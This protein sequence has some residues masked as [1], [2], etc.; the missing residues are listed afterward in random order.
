MIHVVQYATLHFSSVVT[1]G[2]GSHSDFYNKFPSLLLINQSCNCS[3]GKLFFSH[4]M[5]TEHSQLFQLHLATLR[6][7]FIF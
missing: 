7:I 5:Q 6:W 4:F 3:Y 1:F 2:V